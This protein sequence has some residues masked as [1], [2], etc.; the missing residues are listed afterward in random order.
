MKNL[1][2]QKVGIGDK[3]DIILGFNTTSSLGILIKFVGEAKVRWL[4]RQTR[5]SGD[6]RD[7]KT[8]RYKDKESSTNFHKIAKAF[9]ANWANMILCSSYIQDTLNHFFLK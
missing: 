4:E 1:K 7:R 5:G 6:N 3:I 2:L 8:I 9:C